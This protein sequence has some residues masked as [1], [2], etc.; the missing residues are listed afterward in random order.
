MTDG[1]TLADS[2]ADFTD[3]SLKGPVNRNEFKVSPM[4][5]TGSCGAMSVLTGTYSGGDPW[6]GYGCNDWSSPAGRADLG[7]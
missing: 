2:W 5:S 3:G 4:Q 1:T 6:V 7:L